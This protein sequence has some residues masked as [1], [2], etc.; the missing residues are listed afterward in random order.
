MCWAVISLLKSPQPVF[1]ECTG[2]KSKLT[3][4]SDYYVAVIQ[5]ST[6]VD[7]SP[8]HRNIQL[9]Y[10]YRKTVKYNYRKNRLWKRKNCWRE[11][12]GI[13]IIINIK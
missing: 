1:T 5:K 12:T 11:R 9:Q 7:F 2:P 13:I 6:A 10:N 3:K 8:M 4:T